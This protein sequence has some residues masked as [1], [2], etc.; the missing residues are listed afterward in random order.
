MRENN[1]IERLLC[2]E[3]RSDCNFKISIFLFNFELYHI[4][5]TNWFYSRPW[6]IS[7]DQLKELLGRCQQRLTEMERKQHW[8]NNL[9]FHSEMQLCH[10]LTSNCKQW[11]WRCEWQWVA[12]SCVWP[13]IVL[14]IRP[15]IILYL[16]HQQ[17]L[18]PGES[19]LALQ[20]LSLIGVDWIWSAE[21]HC[22]FCLVFPTF[23]STVAFSS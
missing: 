7:Q 2:Q 16:F 13:I 22:K 8:C 21:F 5:T 12:I 17:T 3:I 11:D 23:Y 6:D 15:L 10:D 14:T 1:S 20:Y 9:V 4:S 19:G 18:H